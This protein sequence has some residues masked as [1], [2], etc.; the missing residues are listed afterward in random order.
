MLGKVLKSISCNSF[1]GQL[2]DLSFYGLQS[3]TTQSEVSL[4][5]GFL[6][7]PD[8]VAWPY[9]SKSVSAWLSPDLIHFQIPEA[10]C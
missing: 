7:E 8:R 9:D 2:D 5:R 3:G 1:Y 6:L 10:V 4:L